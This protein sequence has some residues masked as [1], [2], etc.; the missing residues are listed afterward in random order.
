MLGQALA[1]KPPPTD[2]EKLLTELAAAVDTDTRVSRVLRWYGD[3]LPEA[4]RFL[5]AAVSMLPNP[6]TVSSV[7]TLARD[8]AF[9]GRLD[10][11]T[12]VQVDAA[13]YRLKGLLH[14]RD[15]TLSA[16]PLVRTAFQPLAMGAAEMAAR[17]GLRDVPSAVS[18]GQ[19]WWKRY[20]E[21]I[22]LLVEAGCWE[23]ADRLCEIFLNPDYWADEESPDFQ[24]RLRAAAAFAGTERRQEGR[25]EDC[26]DHLGPERLAYYR[27]AIGFFA[28]RAGRGTGDL[29]TASAHLA[30]ATDGARDADRGNWRYRSNLSTGLLELAD[31]LSWLGKLEQARQAAEKALKLNDQ[32]L[33]VMKCHLYLGRIETLAGKTA[34]ADQHFIE[35]DRIHFSYRS[36][37]G[38]WGPLRFPFHQP[39]RHLLSFDGADWA[40]FLV[41]TGRIE[42]ARALAERNRKISAEKPTKKP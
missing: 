19:G 30:T 15:G 22:E 10:G 41:R 13:L 23:Q 5:V 4:D 20:P 27:Y 39:G 11:W 33:E 26:A 24:L 29:E 38:G 40:E 16:H 12:P 2:L 25:Q 34:E 17:V 35:A 7:L 9:G 18:S 42:A 8:T 31:C 14:H 21:V 6:A 36:D 37:G 3:K 1:D 28:M 32:P